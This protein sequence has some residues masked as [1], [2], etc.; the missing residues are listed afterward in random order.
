MEQWTSDEVQTGELDFG[1]PK[2]NSVDSNVLCCAQCGSVEVIVFGIH[3]MQVI[4]RVSG[5]WREMF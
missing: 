5:Q 4:I 3:V 1:N 2:H